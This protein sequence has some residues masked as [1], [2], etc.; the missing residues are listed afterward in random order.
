M[1]GEGAS[2]AYRLTP[3]ALRVL[4]LLALDVQL[5]AERRR[6]RGWR[7]VCAST[8]RPPSALPPGGELIHGPRGAHVGAGE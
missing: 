5:A 4:P 1:R 2:R 8:G 3:A 6:Q 7:T